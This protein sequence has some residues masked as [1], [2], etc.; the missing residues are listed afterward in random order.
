MTADGRTEFAESLR[1]SSII[2]LLDLDDTQIE[3]LWRFRALVLETN[4][5]INLTRITAPRDFAVKHVVDSLA[6]CGAIAPSGSSTI[7]VLDVGTGAGIPA[8]PLSIARRDWSV[9]AID[10]TGKKARFVASVAETLRLGNLVAE[11]ARAETWRG[12]EPFDVVTF[13]AVGSLA[14]CV[15]LGRQHLTG[16]GR[17]VVFKTADVAADE[18][19]DGA[20]EARRAGFTVEQPIVYELELGD[21]SIR[22][23]LR[24]FRKIGN[25]RSR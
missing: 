15:R 16:G 5:K 19:A 8:V 11:Q 23:S 14:H 17:M 20:N 22:R 13:K 1:A 10:G 18:L 6:I 12:S 2:Q 21:E 7:R 3:Q 4:A 9:H 25:Q 24:V